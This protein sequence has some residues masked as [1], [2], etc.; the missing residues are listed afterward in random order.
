LWPD[1]IRR[2]LL[3]ANNEVSMLRLSALLRGSLLAAI[4]LAPLTPTAPLMS[5]DMRT[6]LAA[7]ANRTAAWSLLCAALNSWLLR[8]ASGPH[9]CSSN[10]N[11]DSVVFAFFLPNEM[12]ARRVEL[13]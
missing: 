1:S 7:S 3:T 6:I 9:R 2:K 5:G 11:A 8:R 10:K 12:I 4:V 13:S